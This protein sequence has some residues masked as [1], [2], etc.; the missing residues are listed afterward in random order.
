MRKAGTH[1]FPKP[2]CSPDGKTIA[3]KSRGEHSIQ[4]RVVAPKKK[5]IK[6][7]FLHFHAGTSVLSSIY[8]K[9]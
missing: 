2:H 9:C 6:G 7:V 4:L 5:D 1:G 3:I 8:R